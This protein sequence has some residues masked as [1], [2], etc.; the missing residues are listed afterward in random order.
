LYSY[1][2]TITPEAPYFSSFN[3]Y[4]ARDISLKSLKSPK[5]LFT[6]LNGG[7]ASGSKVK[8]S[9]FYLIIDV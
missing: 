2:R 4:N 7:K 8:F 6:V 5:L 1:G 9:T 3:F